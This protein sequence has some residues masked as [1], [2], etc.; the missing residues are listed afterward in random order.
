[1]KGVLVLLL[2]LSLGHA[3]Q[4]G[5][6]YMRDKICQEFNN[7]GKNDFRT[8]TIIMNSKKFSNATFE[9]I[10]HIV[11]EMVSL[12]ETCCAEGADP[13]CYDEGS[14]ALSDKSCDENSPFPMHAGTADCC[15]HQGLEKKLCLAAL[16][17]PP[18][19]FPTYVEPSNEEL[20]DAF[21]KDPKDFADKFLYEYSSNF[22]QAPLPLLVASTGSYLSMVS[23]CCISP[24]P[25]I[26]FLKERLER[27]T[28][29]I[30][31]R[32]ANRVCSQLAVYGKEKTKFSSLV[33]FSQKIPC[34]SFEEIL[35][36]AEDAA[37][38]FSKFCNSTTED[39]VQKELSEHTTKICSTLSSKD[40]KFADC[41]QGKNL[42]QDYLCIYSLQHAKVTSLPDIDT[43]TNEQLC[44]EDRDQNS[45]R[46]MFEISRRYTSIPEVFLSK[47][48]DATK[49]V[50]D[51]CC[52]AVD[53]TGCLNNK[54]RQGK[55]EVSQFLEKANKLCGEYTN[56]TFLEFKKRL[57]DNFQK[58]MTGATPEYI[59]ELVEDRANFA[60]TCCTMNSPPLYCDLKIKAEAG[61][62]CDYESCRLI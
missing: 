60:S 8:L 48:Y 32:M 33:M 34:A 15:T 42:M 11:K 18:K 21:K 12:V 49:K 25:G 45:Y 52:R 53:V 10:S 36:L 23:T 13:N 7:L 51:E 43:P 57:K 44:S 17:H 40:E 30:T 6:D 50:M 62:T 56:N 47:L 54:K 9:E 3:L 16:H 29:S 2:A 46:Y 14:S 1:M 27:K 5:R 58:T 61:R 59:T 31:T 35:P 28:V 41:C 19:E 22:G 26:C 38:V 39:S 20:C 37:E 55:K 24:S 4:R